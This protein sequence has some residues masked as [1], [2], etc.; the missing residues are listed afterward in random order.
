[1]RL[2]MRPRFVLHFKTAYTRR[3]FYAGEMTVEQAKHRVPIHRAMRADVVKAQRGKTY[4]PRF[5][6]PKAQR[7]LKYAA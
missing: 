2:N 6:V 4:A 1:M 3:M 7:R 5:D